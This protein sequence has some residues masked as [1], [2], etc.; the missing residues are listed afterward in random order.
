MVF[1]LGGWMCAKNF[2]PQKKVNAMKYHKE[3]Q[4]SMHSFDKRTVVRKMRMKFGIWM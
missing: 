4:T 2:L 3:P 1:E